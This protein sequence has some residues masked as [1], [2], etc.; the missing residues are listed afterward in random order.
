MSDG[1]YFLNQ[2][3]TYVGEQR[4]LLPLPVLR[5]R[6]GVRACRKPEVTRG[7]GQALTLARSRSTGRGDQKALTDVPLQPEVLQ[8][9]VHA[10]EDLR[11]RL[12]NERARRPPARPHHVDL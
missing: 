2:D 5:E 8:R 4:L 10:A 12:R 11:R 6:V 9:L 7:F 1:I 3:R